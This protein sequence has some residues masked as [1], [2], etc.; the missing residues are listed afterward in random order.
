M[1]DH[2]FS[3]IY[4]CIY[5]SM[6]VIHHKYDSSKH[7]KGMMLLAQAKPQA[8]MHTLHIVQ[9]NNMPIFFWNVLLKIDQH[10][11]RYRRCW[12]RRRQRWAFQF[13]C[14]HQVYHQYNTLR[15]EIGI[16]CFYRFN[17]I[18]NTRI[19]YNISSVLVDHNNA[20][21]MYIYVYKWHS[22]CFFFLSHIV[23]R[24]G[25]NSLP[26]LKRI[27]VSLSCIADRSIHE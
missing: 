14:L 11:H 16:F 6:T 2:K 4:S 7:I 19:E 13:V 15:T 1:K 17:C 21:D 24:C 8:Y 23:I 22:S 25:L 5:H 3:D 20:F 9:T 10:Q 27:F 26:H 12:R 18:H